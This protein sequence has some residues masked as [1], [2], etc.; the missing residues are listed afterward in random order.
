M[1]LVRKIKQKLCKHDMK[2]ESAYETKVFKGGK[3]V[4]NGMYEHYVCTK[5]GKEENIVIPK[6]IPRFK[7][8]YN[9][10]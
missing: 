8:I 7:S 2:K 6:F 4:E 10:L 1:S 3:L 9:D 5:C